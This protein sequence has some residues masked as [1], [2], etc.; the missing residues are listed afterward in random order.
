MLNREQRRAYL[1]NLGKKFPGFTIT[2]GVVNVNINDEDGKK[3]DTVQ[4]DLNNFKTVTHLIRM[5]AVFE[6]AKETY[7]EE[8]T[9]VEA[10]TSKLQ[11]MILMGEIY[12]K[13]VA[14]VVGHVDAIFGEGSAVKI[15]G[16]DSPMPV[17]VT[18]FVSDFMPLAKEMAA[19]MNP[20]AGVDNVT[21]AVKKASKRSKKAADRQGDV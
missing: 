17:V 3:R 12:E 13:L 20:S 10:A 19:Y 9:A 2:D 6:S 16:N 1:K 4:M 8:Y 18:S 11:Q 15:F 5:C 14:E 7:A 21:T